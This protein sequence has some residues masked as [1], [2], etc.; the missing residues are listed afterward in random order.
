MQAP[1][2]HGDRYHPPMPVAPRRRHVLAVVLVAACVRLLWASAGVPTPQSDFR[3][4]GEAAARLAAGGGYAMGDGTATAYWPMGWPLILSVPVR[5]GVGLGGGYAIQIVAGALTA[6]L[7]TVGAS[8]CGVSARAAVAGGLIYALLPGQA[9]AA[10]LLATEPAFTLALTAGLVVLLGGSWTMRRVVASAFLIGLATWIRP[11]TLVWPMALLIAA[12]LRREG[13][14]RSVAIALATG[15]VICATI[16]P[17]TIRNYVRLHAFVPVSTNG[18][19][20]LLQGTKVDKGYWEPRGAEIS[21]LPETQRD[22]A[23]R[24]AALAYWSEHPVEMLGRVPAKIAALWSGDSDALLW[25]ARGGVL[26]P[27]ATRTWKAVAD[28]ALFGL[29]GLAIGGFVRAIRARREP[30]WLLGTFVVA[31]M[32]LFAFFPA[33]PRFHAPVMPALAMLSAVALSRSWP[34]PTLHGA[35]GEAIARATAPV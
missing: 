22:V 6:G 5:L 20:N 33:G 1:C 10:T 14:R 13:V 16:A 28:L 23:A 21:G 12:L 35:S 24:T 9:A 7:V 15:A 26:S 11:V 4:Y 34:S 25:M 18:G 30:A 29:L 19:V 8:R 32:A 2:P 3:F 31:Y 17:L 27:S